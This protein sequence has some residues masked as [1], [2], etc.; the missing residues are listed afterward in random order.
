[1]PELWTLAVSSPERAASSAKR[2]EAAGW[3]GIAVVDSQNLSGDSYV[4]LALAAAASERIGLATGVTNPVTRHP[5]VTASAIASIQRISGGRAVLGIG[6]GDSALAHLGRAPARVAV[7]ER[8][9][10][11]LQTYLRGDGLAFDAIDFHERIAPPIDTL[12]LADSPSRSRLHWL[13]R[14]APKVPVEVAATGPRVIAAAARHAD[15][16]MFALGADPR[17]ITW[18]IDQARAARRDAGLP[19]DGIA[20]GAYVN[21][22]CHPDV[23]I[24]RQL[25]AGGLA[26]FARFSV[27]HGTVQGP[28]TDEQSRV[29]TQIHDGYDMRKHTRADSE[30]TGGLT[31]EFVDRYAIVGPPDHCARRIAELEALGLE[32]LVVIGATAGAD[33]SEATRSAEVLEKE[34]LPGFSAA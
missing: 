5:A 32:K 33:R 9:L 3:A 26:T 30:H 13:D 24:A 31:P 6:R 1:M 8:Y 19:A 14:N 29:L 7:L 17:R 2:A 20:Y 10:I 23:A 21:M 11:A 25:V 15:R 4:A 28:V 27:M 12:G 18:G 34:V 22:V 16:V